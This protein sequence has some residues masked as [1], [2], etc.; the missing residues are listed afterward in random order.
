[1]WVALLLP[2]CSTPA[3]APAPV[4]APAVTPEA[5]PE[6]AEA[7][8]EKPSSAARKR[9]PSLTAI[10]ITP[11]PARASDTL[12]AK[13]EAA[14][15][16]GPGVDLDFEWRVN[17]APIVDV[18]SETLRGRYKKG[19]SVTVRVTA[20]NGTDTVSLDSAPLVIVNTPPVFETDARAMKRVD[21]F[22][23]KATDPDDDPL[24]WRIE[25]APKG[26]GISPKGVLSYAGSE[27]EPGGR[28]SIA[29]IVDDGDAFGRF[30]F[31]LTVTAGSAAK[32]AEK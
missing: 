20:D 22:T 23:F 25:G 14:N 19:D 3:P 8:A 21:G 31:P 9:P 28:Y 24:S 26:M 4:A 27:D 6:A 5:S 1:M 2:A 16:D 7:S 13:L 30:E 11:V 12:V 18:T 32:K 10:D 29:V 15:I 17:G